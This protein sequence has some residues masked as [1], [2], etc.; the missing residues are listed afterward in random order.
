IDYRRLHAVC[1]ASART[2][3]VHPGS[4][5][6][7]LASMQIKV[8]GAQRLFGSVSHV[9]DPHFR[10]PYGRGYGLKADS[11][12]PADNL[13]QTLQHPIFG[14]VLPHFLFGISIA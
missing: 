9:V 6:F 13:E 3:A 4:A 14:E 11:E 12:Q 1:L 2:F 5:L 10:M 8:Q 7:A